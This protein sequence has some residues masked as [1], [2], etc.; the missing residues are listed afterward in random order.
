MHPSDLATL[1]LGD[2][3]DLL[4]AQAGMALALGLPVAA[5]VW[6]YGGGAG[7][8]STIVGLHSYAEAPVIVIDR[9]LSTPVALSEFREGGVFN[10]LAN[11]KV[12]SYVPA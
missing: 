11:F 6:D 12:V 7:H 1:K 8:V 3:D 5:L 10:D 4:R 9:Q 2:C